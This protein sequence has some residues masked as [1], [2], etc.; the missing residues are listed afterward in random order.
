[1]R[2]RA[3]CDNTRWPVAFALRSVTAKNICDC[4]MKVWMTFGVSQ[5][6]SMDNAAYNTSKLTKILMENMGCSPIFITPGH[7]AGNTLAERTIGTIKEA[8]H[9]VAFDHQRSWYKYLDHILWALREILHCSTGVSPWQMAL[10]FLPRGPCAVLKDAW[11]GDR[12]L[13]VNLGQPVAVYLQELRDRLAAANEYAD[14]HLAHEQKRWVS[15]YNLRSSNKQFIAGQTVMILTPDSTSSRLWSRWR[16]PA[17]V[18]SKQSDYSYLVE[19][20]GSTQLVHANKLR[21]YDV[22]V[23][24]VICTSMCFINNEMCD[25]EN[26]ESDAVECN[27]CDFIHVNAC[28]VIYEEDEDFGRIQLIEPTVVEHVL[29]PSQCIDSMALRHLT[30]QQQT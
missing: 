10:G 23:N 12:D 4:L 29:L 11:T 25:N 27:E 22:R 21:P 20:D 8:I 26:I 7:S 1:L 28:S 18:I 3:C 14:E 2:Y 19:Y 13:L 30:E 6:V 9:K 16:A 15:R 17:K 5:F 24:E